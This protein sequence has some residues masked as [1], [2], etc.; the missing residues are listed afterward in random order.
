MNPK[1]N[2]P[3][4]RL[5]KKNTMQSGII[6]PTFLMNLGLS[7]N[8]FVVLLALLILLAVKLLWMVIM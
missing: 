1:F 8:N 3:A 2:K 6:F 7:I 5:V 4:K